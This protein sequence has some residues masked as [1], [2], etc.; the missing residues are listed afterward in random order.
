MKDS[1]V[2]ITSLS[3]DVFVPDSEL[4]NELFDKK[5]NL[6]YFQDNHI[7]D[8]LPVLKCSDIDLKYISAYNDPKTMDIKVSKPVTDDENLEAVL[9]D[10][11]HAMMR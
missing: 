3:S 11:R 6:L 7:W 10:R 4:L 1:G 5:V 8:I 9:Q 2:H